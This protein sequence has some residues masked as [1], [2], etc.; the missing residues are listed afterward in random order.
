MY[1]TLRPALLLVRVSLGLFML[2][3]ALEKVLFPEKTI[4]IFERFYMMEISPEIAMALGVPQILLSIAII[5]GLWKTFSYGGGLII[6]ALSTL[7]TYKELL[8]PYEGIN[9]L[10]TAAVP[11]LAAFIAL[12]MLRDKDR[13]FAL[14]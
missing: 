13:M 3:W 4:G 14:S 11:V 7:S 2:Q 5:L 6:H 1:D 10:F 8:N 12:F 9:H